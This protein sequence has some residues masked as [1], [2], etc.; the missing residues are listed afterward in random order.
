MRL[1]FIRQTWK[2]PIF[3]R[4]RN[5]IFP[6]EFLVGPKLLDFLKSPGKIIC[7]IQKN[8][9]RGNNINFQ[10]AMAMY[11]PTLENSNFLQTENFN[12]LK[13]FPAPPWF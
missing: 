7:R 2:I 3:T 6:K 5:L 8:S 12:I 10:K 4:P 11:R 13:I 1:G 9:F